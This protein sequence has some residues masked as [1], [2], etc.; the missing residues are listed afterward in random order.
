M[1]KLHSEYCGSEDFYFVLKN[2]L[3]LVKNFKQGMT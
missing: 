2:V 1:H 3:D